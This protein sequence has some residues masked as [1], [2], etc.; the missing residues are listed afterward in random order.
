MAQP[1]IYSEP[2]GAIDDQLREHLDSMRSVVI[3]Q[4]ATTIAAYAQLLA[5]G[6]PA[7]ATS[8]IKV[9]YKMAS[10]ASNTADMCSPL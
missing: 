9:L 1:D 7:A 8:Q 2:E 4:A 5:D 6:Q 3:K 10:I